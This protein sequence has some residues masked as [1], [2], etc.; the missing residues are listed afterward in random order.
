MTF[1]LFEFQD[2]AARSLSDAIADWVT[3]VVDRGRPPTTVDGDPIPLFAHLTAITGAG[4]TPILAR[5]MGSVG[6]A[7]VL[8]TTNRS[9]VIDQTVEK[10]RT[11]YRHFLPPDTTIIGE[12]PTQAEWTALMDDEAGV[13][14]WCLTVASWNDTDETTRGTAEAR[15]NIHRPAPDWA[16]EQSPWDQLGDLDGRK[17]PLWVVYDEGHGQTDVQLDQLLS[18]NPV[19]IIAASGTPS[20]SPRIDQLRDSLRGSEVY[21]PVVDAA[22]VEIPTTAVAAAGLLKSGIEMVDLN[23]DA[24]SKIVAAVD[25]LRLL[26]DLAADTGVAL[27]P[28]AIYVVEESD[29]RTGEPRPVTIW[30]TLTAHCGVDPC[31]IAVATSTREL[32]RDAERVTDLAQ[33]RPRHRHLIFNKKFQEGW[34][35]PDA[36]VAYFDGET[37]SA[38]RIKQII[39]RVIRQPGAR[40]FEGTADLNTAFLYMSSPDARFASIVESIRR[41]LVEEYGADEAGEPNVRVRRRSERPPLVPLREGLPDLSLPVLIITAA[42]LEPLF[43]R[44]TAAANRPFEPADLDAPGTATRMT[45]TLT[46]TQQRITAQVAEIGRH[47]R[48]LNRDYFRDRC[49]TLSREA[50]DR[51]PEAPLAGAMFDQTSAAGS[52]AQAEVGRLAVEYVTD[53]EARVRYAQEPDPAHDTWRPRPLDTTRPA[54]LAFARSVHLA[55]PDAPSFLNTPERA[56]AAALDAAGDGWWVR[57]PPTRALG[58]YGVPMPVQVGGS[59]TFFPDFL[60]WVDE[61]CFA[62]DTTG[63][64]LLDAKV[65]GKLLALTTPRIALVTAGRVSPNL[66]TLEER[67]GW[68][69]VL[70]GT[71]GPRRTHHP[72]LA[73]VLAALRAE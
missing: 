22:M 10:L 60:W 12:K 18:L 26:D 71:A 20:F 21:G 54:T 24:E 69:L 43:E 16:G 13:V 32:P 48:T 5:V 45:F 40:H 9:V 25:Q 55:Y 59:Q 72:A 3:R 38:T 63:V 53:F 37:R 65:R 4:K 31:S 35:D 41:H 42:G 68:T 15:L 64:H 14:I 56:M 70:P 57:N 8:W 28:R 7:I 62:I 44:L 1:A 36:Y 39:G 49:R 17:R 30:N 66:D 19:G 29:R 27:S 58:G 47:I 6:P 51:L 2:A 50:F 61:H 11:T 33:L 67:A 52:V 46:E 23:T 73:Q 34:D